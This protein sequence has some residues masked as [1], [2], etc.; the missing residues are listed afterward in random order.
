M[1][2]LP[3]ILRHMDLQPGS[4]IGDYQVVAL[5][6][7]GDFATVYRG[8]APDGHASDERDVAIKVCDTIEQKQ[9]DRIAIEADALQRF[10]HRG[11]PEFISQGD[12]DGHPYLVMGLATGRTVRE[13]IEEHRETNQRFSDVTVI[14]VLK[15]LLDILA[16][17]H[18]ESLKHTYGSGWVHRDLKDANVMVNDS[19]DHVRL[20]DFGFCKES[21]SAVMRG[22]DSFFRAGAAR[23][24]PPS[25]HDSPANANP[26]HDVFAAGVLGYLMLTNQYPWSVSTEADSGELCTKMREEKPTPIRMLN[27]TVRPE[28]CKLIESLIDTRDAHRPSSEEVL[29]EVDKVLASITAEAPE[30]RYGSPSQPLKLNEVWRDALYGDIR[31]TEYETRII[32][33]PEMQ[34]LRHI[35]QLGF[36]NLVYASADH[37]RLSHSVGCVHRVEEILRA[38]EA[39]EG[40]QVDQE[41]RLVARLYALVHDVTHIAYGHTLEDELG[42]FERHDQNE[43][44]IRRLVL[45][46][47][48][49]LGQLLQ[50]N[51]IGRSVLSHFDLSATMYAR[52]DIKELVTGMM[53]AD[54][55]DYIDRDSY[56]LG[57]DHRVDSAVFRQFCFDQRSVSQRPRVVSL[58]Q[59][60]Y[61]MRIDREFAIE[62][63]MTERYA[64]FL[65]AYTHR[66]KAKASAMLG[67]ALALGIYGGQEPIISEEE[68]EWHTDDTLL[69]FLETARRKRTREIAV[70]LR[71][72]ALPIAVFRSHLLS[73]SQRDMESYTA[74]CQDL[75]VNRSQFGLC[76]PIDRLQVE[77]ELVRGIS[78]LDSDQ[79]IVYTTP[80][81]PGLKRT[82][83]HR[84]VE[85]VGKAP[86]QGTSAW[87]NRLRERHM[88]LWDLWVFVDPDATESQRSLVAGAAGDRFGFPNIIEDHPRQDRLW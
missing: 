44:R 58:L 22:D 10:R 52:S 30:G 17:M 47:R 9:L 66:T 83:A 34:R 27:N 24:S 31:L 8:H 21:G 78:G 12:I 16:Y 86:T 40:V 76:N 29:E 32:D 28:V 71:R 63:V 64:L 15:Q 18:S 14:R 73:E 1:T 4:Y 60:D 36:T 33:S 42:F 48:S 13:W 50:A 20:I 81:A 61:G 85:R 3:S 49:T 55:L 7:R 46:E 51:S 77:S 82:Q 87:F 35:K 26:T 72:R 38:M 43:L 67:K 57:L 25:K 74:L 2:A 68:I 69:Y 53:G 56:F 11:I 54:L 5:L 62:S 19:R 6:G 59:G 84:V 41:T 80:T 39:V 45:G 23:Y 88:G 65:K 75:R 70:A 79:V 37:S